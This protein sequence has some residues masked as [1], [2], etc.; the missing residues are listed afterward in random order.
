M[1]TLACISL[2][3]CIKIF[4]GYVNSGQRVGI[5]S[6]LV[7]IMKTAFQKNCTDPYFSNHVDE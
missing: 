4:V 7:F 2:N 5:F 6:F 3:T 1:N